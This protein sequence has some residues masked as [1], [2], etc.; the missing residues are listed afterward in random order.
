MRHVGNVGS[1]AILQE[2]DLSHNCSVVEMLVKQR[3]FRVATKNIG[4]QGRSQ[5]G[6]D[7]IGE[8]EII[9]NVINDLRLH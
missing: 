8:L 9:D 2:V 5:S 6:L 3:S 7:I 4:G 1:G